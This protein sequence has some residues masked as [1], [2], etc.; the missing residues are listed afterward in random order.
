ME[1]ELQS[2]QLNLGHGGFTVIAV[3]PGKAH[4]IAFAID[5]TAQNV[6]VA[7]LRV[8]FFDTTWHVHPDV[9][10]EGTK[11]L[12]ILAFPNPA[13]TGV[14]SVRRNDA[15]KAAVGYVVY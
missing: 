10:V 7:R 9:V 8:A 11:G 5:N 12:A 14:V 2:G 3:P 13:K 4:Q 6:P 15:G 1:A